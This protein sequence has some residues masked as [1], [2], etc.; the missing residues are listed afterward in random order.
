MSFLVANV[1][2]VFCWIRKEFIYDF[3]RGHGEYEPCY[4]VSVKSIR[5]QA[6][7]FEAFLPNYGALYDKL[8][9]SAFVS[10]E[11]DL[12]VDEFL[13]L[14]HL[15]LWNCNSYDIT[16]IRKSFL[17]GLSCKFI[18][19]NK[20]WYRGEYLF[21]IDH[22]HPDPN[23]TPTLFSEEPM[24]HK[25]YNIVQMNNGQFAAQPNNRTI[26]IDPSSKPS[27]LKYPDF[28]VATVKY[29]VEHDEKW[30][31]GDSS[32]FTFDEYHERKKLEE[33][34]NVKTS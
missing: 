30:S 16:V 22:A 14:D 28:E 10:R 23:I 34:Q 5:N 1:P 20:Q 31:C 11:H 19:K 6:L 3:K 32:K 7:R 25:S 27:E 26:F 13:P 12:N 2:S 18:A 17:G 24:D 29:S 15:Q 9:I 8:P 33:E 21:T 4:W